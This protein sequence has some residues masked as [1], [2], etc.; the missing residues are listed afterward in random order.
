MRSKSLLG[1]AQQP[2]GARNH[3]SGVL[4]RHI[5]P[6]IDARPGFLVFDRT[7]KHR[8]SANF[9]HMPL[10][11]TAR[12]CWHIAV[13]IAVRAGF[14]EFDRTRKHRL[15]VFLL[16]HSVEIIARACSAATR[17]SKSLLERA[18]KLLSARNCCLSRLLRIR[19]HSKTPP[20]LAYLHISLDT[21]ARACSAATRRCS[22][23]FSAQNRCTSKLHVIRKHSRFSFEISFAIV[24]L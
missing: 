19:Q 5:A 6:E 1:H 8:L 23:T 21:T 18:S 7:R 20:Q 22:K 12:A 17:R 2:L 14:L 13:V 16:A 3:C 10:E 11:I 15:S 24:L 9:P 4:R